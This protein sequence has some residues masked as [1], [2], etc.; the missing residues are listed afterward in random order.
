MR[1]KLAVLAIGAACVGCSAPPVA[2]ALGADHPANP[3]APSVPFSRPIDILTT[4]GTPTTGVPST[5]MRQMPA[6]SM[7]GMDHAAMS[8][9]A[10]RMAQATQGSA[11]S[12]V[13]ASGKVNSIDPAKH[14]INITHEPIKALGW[15]SMTMDFP[16]NAS[17]DLKAIKPGEKIDFSL[18]R[19]DASGNRRI[20]HLQSA[21]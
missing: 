7:A 8:H 19:A 16:V 2:V 9:D 1:S 13:T 17:I 12:Q 10:T 18:G 15:P 21:Q 20:E 6:G 4:S 14:T 11:A 5:A 3:D